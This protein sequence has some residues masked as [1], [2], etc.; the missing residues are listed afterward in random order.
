MYRINVRLPV[1]CVLLAA[2]PLA[3]DPFPLPAP[4]VVPTDEANAPFLLPDGFEQHLIVDRDTLEAEGL[5]P[6]FGLWDMIALDPAGRYVFVPSEVGSG[7]GV[8][9][10]DLETGRHLTLMLGNASGVRTADPSA[11]NP[12][13][14]DFS[15][16]DPATYTPWG[17]VLTGEE[18]TGGR[19][20]EI[21]N[22]LVAP[23]GIPP[24]V[25]AHVPPPF[26]FVHVAWRSK[27]PAVAHE[28]LRFDSH[29]VLYFIDEDN[30]GSIYKFVPYRKNR[31]DR[32]Q[33]FVLK[34]DAFTGNPAQNWNSATNIATV[35]SGL[36]T[37]VPITDARG[38]ALTA[39]DPFEFVT[40][41]GGRAAADE[42]GGTPYGRPEDMSVGTLA[43]G[44][45]V[46]YC[47]VTSENLVIAIELVGDS[48]AIVH[49]FVRSTVTVNQATG[50]AVGGG[51]AGH[52]SPDN[53]EVGHDGTVYIIEDSN[54]GDIWRATDAN[55][56]GV[57]ESIGRWAS[58]GVAGSEPTGLIS[59][60]NDAKRF[61]VVVQHPSSGNDA[62]WEIIVP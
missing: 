21:T 46:I 17:T 31:L 1:L 18:T 13:N 15:R 60:P 62:L 57:A 2:G 24:A 28:G 49:D 36:A 12:R 16:F 10:Y 47:A 58:L 37:W 8:F 55:R 38:N 43:S 33:S 34:V 14:D 35:R 41:T 25:L 23:A 50:V 6:T 32:G 44:N 7:A 56:D 3:A 42:A 20:F 52:N 61:L 53:I 48:T 22:P 29:G 51:S 5:P 39:A 11:F 59:D 26:P 19:L 54:P 4:A 9:R 27:I 45:E 40:T 30:S